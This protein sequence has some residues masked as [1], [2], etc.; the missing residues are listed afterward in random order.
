MRI[1]GQCACGGVSFAAD[2][3]P[4]VQLICH[5]PSCQ[6]AHGAPMV[7]GAHFPADRFRSDGS[8]IAVRVSRGPDATLR[9]TCPTCGTRVFNGSGKGPRTIFPVL[10]SNSDWFKPEMHLYWSNRRL[11]IIDQLPKYLDFPSEFGGTG[12][13]SP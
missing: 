10:C 11:E 7:L 3:E 12:R 6:L 2:G 13:L 4:L 9:M 5:C 1:E 8:L